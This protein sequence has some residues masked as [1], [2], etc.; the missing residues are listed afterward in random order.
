MLKAACRRFHRH[1]DRG[2]PDPHQRS[3]PACARYARTVGM[4]RSAGLRRD[5]PPRLAL[6]LR[7][8]AAARPALARPLLGPDLPAGLDARLRRIPALAASSPPPSLRSPVPAVAAST[9]IVVALSLAFGNPYLAGAAVARR[10]A[11]ST[12]DAWSEVGSRSAKLLSSLTEASAQARDE[13]T[14]TGEDLLTATERLLDRARELPVL[15]QDAGKGRGTDEDSAPTSPSAT[16]I[17]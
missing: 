10:I 8:I 17:P 5:L 7:R 14:A 6:R 16:T 4:A 1:F 12:A 13:V 3:C 2:V 9:L 11:G 15:L